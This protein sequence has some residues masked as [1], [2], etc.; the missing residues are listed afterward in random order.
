H[1][2][3]GGAAGGAGGSSAAATTATTTTA[4]GGA[5]AAIVAGTVAV[6]AV[7][8]GGAAYVATH[9]HH[10]A[11]AAFEPAV[12]AAYST[13]PDYT[14]NR[15]SQA[16]VATDTGASVPLRGLRVAPDA[17]RGPRDIRLAASA[18]GRALAATDGAHLVVASGADPAEQHSLACSCLDVMF[19]T[20][21]HL[22]VLTTSWRLV[23]YDV[24]GAA[25]SSTADVALTRTPP[26]NPR[27]DTGYAARLLSVLGEDVYAALP[28]RPGDSTID[29]DLVR[30]DL[31]TGQTQRLDT[32]HDGFAVT[33]ARSDDGRYAALTVAAGDGCDPGRLAVIDLATTAPRVRWVGGPTRQTSGSTTFDSLAHVG[34]QGD[35]LAVSWQRGA[36]C[37]DDSS[38]SPAELFTSEPP[39]YG[40]WTSTAP[41]LKDGPA[42]GATWAA[43]GHDGRL[44]SLWQTT[45]M[46]YSTQLW[47]GDPDA[48]GREIAGAVDEVV[49]V[50]S[51]GTPAASPPG[52]GKTVEYDVDPWFAD[53]T[54][55]PGYAIEDYDPYGEASEDCSFDRGSPVART[56]N[57]HW[58]G[59][60]ADYTYACWNDGPSTT[61]MLCLSSPWSRVIRRVQVTGF[62]RNMPR[63]S[64][65]SPYG[66]ELTDGQLC[67]FRIGG[68][69]GFTPPGT[70][71]IYGCGD[72]S[73]DGEPGWI[74]LGG[75]G[76][77][78]RKVNGQWKVLAYHDNGAT[79][80]AGTERPQW[81]DIATVYWM[82]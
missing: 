60:T 67:T 64:N 53:G 39:S 66:I 58:C 21:G 44:L 8:G 38:T 43:P 65:P 35:A 57:T 47:V 9:E 10:A 23:T 82:T 73:Q 1:A 6:A 49:P 17:S 42:Y 16:F 36:S 28:G 80:P 55:K 24:S 40:T 2:A 71:A 27:W 68:A 59:S 22:L 11:P 30:I 48:G 56:V 54:L 25:P 3:A 13:S 46:A 33:S 77:T 31:A 50:G 81:I 61:S 15:A 12:L 70:G 52:S 26:K 75:A 41:V 51:P 20:D 18:D 74:L 79:S 7:G 19:T 45:V 62:R 37:S 5:K 14:T 72:P 29:S 4:L 32:L 34:F 69:W 63:P 78:F 76:P